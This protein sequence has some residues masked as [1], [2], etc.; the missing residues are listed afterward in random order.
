MAGAFFINYTADF[1]I[2]VAMDKKYVF[3]L[4]KLEMGDILLL[5][6][7]P[8]YS[9]IMQRNAGSIY[10][11]AMLYV[12]GSSHLHSDKGPGV[13]S[14][15]TSRMLFEK[16]D[17]A[18][19]LRL[20]DPKN[21]VFIEGVIAHARAKVGTEYSSDEAK[22][23]IAEHSDEEF[24]ANRQFCTRFVA[25]SY[26]DGGL[27]VV[28]DPNYC[29]PL[30]LTNSEY[31][32]IVGEVLIEANQQQIDYAAEVNPPLKK[33]EQITKDILKYARDLTGKDIQTF[34]Q[35]TDWLM[36]HPEGD[37]EIT[38]FIKKSGFLEMWKEDMER[39]PEHYYL[40]AFQQNIEKKH[41]RSAAKQIYDLA[42]NNMYRY[43]INFVAYES[44]YQHRKLKYIEIH[45]E[46]YQNL[47][48]AMQQMKQVAVDILNLK[49]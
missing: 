23:T 9:A 30:D 46:L 22:R 40:Q 15:N 47:I 34:N 3:D 19:A 49:P 16:P 17:A 29:T 20:K 38:S 2:F 44:Y 25:Q 4:S 48:L 14:D 33:Q 1:P 31:F 26:A 11:H 6:A 41:W 39:N 21:K 43:S 13:Q 37:E 12:G 5:N 10:H 45:I 35:L 42:E 8:R 32:I 28:P 36:E 18:I 24:E 7:V 27:V